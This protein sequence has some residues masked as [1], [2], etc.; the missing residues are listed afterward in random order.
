MV[1]V[2][3]HL[4]FTCGYTGDMGPKGFIL[5]SESSVPPVL[6]CSSSF[7]E[8]FRRTIVWRQFIKRL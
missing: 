8:N 6:L 5:S 3:V 4:T 7:V 2:K 1:L